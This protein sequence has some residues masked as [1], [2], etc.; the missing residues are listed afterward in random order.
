[1][2]MLLTTLRRNRMTVIAISYIIM[3]IF[4][5]YL[6]A[7]GYETTIIVMGYSKKQADAKENGS[8]EDDIKQI[9]SDEEDELKPYNYRFKVVTAVII[10]IALATF[11]VYRLK[12]VTLPVAHSE[13]APLPIAKLVDMESQT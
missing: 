5:I 8:S 1:M 11:C 3:L 9:N 7:I 10:P 12:P 13:L 4:L 2:Y 6:L